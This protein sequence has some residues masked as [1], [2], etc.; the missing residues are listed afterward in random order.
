MNIFE[1]L[2]KRRSIRKYQSKTVETEKITKILEAARL[3]PSANNQ[4]P[5]YFIVVTKPEIKED[6]RGAYKADWFLHAPVIIVCCVNPKEAWRRGLFGEEYWKVDAAIALQNLILAATELELGT[7]WIANFDEKAIKRTL[8]IPNE[9]RVIAMTPIGYPDEK[10]EPVTDRKPL[11]KI[12]HNEN[13]K[14]E[15][16]DPYN[17]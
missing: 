5:C 16:T 15:K 1:V 6:L 13:G 9:I 14:S 11:D 3:G 7:C 8:N 2:E 4:Q 17:N 10:K 12:V